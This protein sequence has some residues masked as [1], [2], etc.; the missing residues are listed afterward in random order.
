[1]HSALYTCMY[2]N[3]VKYFC[4]H[5]GLWWECVCVYKVF[6]LAFGNIKEILSWGREEEATSG[7]RIYI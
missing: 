5:D 3:Q 1:M 2:T 4:K 6:N 7:F